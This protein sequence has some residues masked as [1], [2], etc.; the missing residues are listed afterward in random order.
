M[1]NRSQNQ[2]ALVVLGAVGAVAAAWFLW[3][4]PTTTAIT[5][6]TAQ[7]NKLVADK[8]AILQRIAMID[9]TAA[10]LAKGGDA[11]KLLNLA[12]PK[13][14]DTETLITRLNSMAVA[15]GVTLA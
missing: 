8:A 1:P 6:A 7:S 12:A 11:Q 3:L 2:L 4:S 13:D 5:A 15:N 9:A 10:D 14:S